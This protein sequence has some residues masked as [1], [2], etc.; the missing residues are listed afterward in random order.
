MGMRVVAI[1]T[2]L[3]AAA[4]APAGSAAQP[5][6]AVPPLTSAQSV[7]ELLYVCIQDEAKVGV[8]DM[9]SRAVVR[10]IDLTK[11]GFSPNAKPHHIVVEPDGSFWYV[12][13]IGDNRVLKIDRDDRV[14]AQLRMETPGMLA[15]HPSD[16]RLF[17]S[18]SMSAV[19]PPPRIGVARRG[20]L[21]VEEIDVFFPRP[22]P[23]IATHTHA[24]TGSLGVNQLAAVDLA[25][26]RVELTTIEGTPHAFVQYA[27]SPDG[28]TLVASAELSGM[29][30]VFDLAVPSKPALVRTVATGPMAFDPV[31]TPDGRFVYVP[32]K[33]A[34]E[35]AIVETSGWTVVD[36]IRHPALRQ[37]HQ[38]VFT[39]DG[40]T[41]FVS[42][43]AKANHMAGPGDHAAHAIGGDALGAGSIVV[44][45]V[46]TRRAVQ[47]IEL[48]KNLTGIGT[49]ARR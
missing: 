6:S 36:R 33:G 31:F 35:V 42:N 29:L 20:D 9:R 10:T 15:L 43:N 5:G 1:A 17:I 25:S 24:Y 4:C 22:H 38:V 44:I 39:A 18:R 3:V 37:P 12:S 21:R 7:A 11:L 48:G 19:N 49:R 46:A 27:I 28:R 23:V 34:N 45:D 30:L 40:A 8:I 32:V 26:E 41:A 16:D 13:L 14:V 47:A 2:A